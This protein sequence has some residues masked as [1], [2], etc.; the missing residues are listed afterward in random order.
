MKDDRRARQVQHSSLGASRIEERRYAD[1]SQRMEAEPVPP[2]R[3][4][5]S[6]LTDA[7]AGLGTE[8]RKNTLMWEKILNQIRRGL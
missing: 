6:N 7:A 3:L 2:E 4:E 5:D 8:C 1:R